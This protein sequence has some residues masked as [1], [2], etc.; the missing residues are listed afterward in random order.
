[1]DWARML[2]YVT[3]R[4]VICR[5]RLGGLLRYYHREAA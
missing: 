1:M 5:E 2:A 4:P 3:G